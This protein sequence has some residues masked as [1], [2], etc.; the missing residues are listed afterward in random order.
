MI[1]DL[2]SHLADS[3]DAHVQRL[4]VTARAIQHLGRQLHHEARALGFA[5]QSTGVVRVVV[6]G[7]P[8]VVLTLVSHVCVS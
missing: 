3:T 8:L 2:F 5:F 6:H 4:G 7:Q 1:Q